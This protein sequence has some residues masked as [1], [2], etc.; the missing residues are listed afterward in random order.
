MNKSGI[1]ETRLE[2]G[3]L[4]E[5]R[6]IELGKSGA[7]DERI[8]NAIAQWADALAPRFD[9]QAI[10][11]AVD[12]FTLYAKY[13]PKLP[14]MMDQCK[15]F[16]NEAQAKVERHKNPDP[17]RTIVESFNMAGLEATCLA[18]IPIDRW[19]GLFDIH[20]AITELQ[21]REIVDMILNGLKLQVIDRATA[22]YQFVQHGKKPSLSPAGAERIARDLAE[23][24]AEGTINGIPTPPEIGKLG[25]TML[26]SGGYK[27]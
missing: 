1:T 11:R 8:E 9:M 7:T 10:R 5:A 4:F 14:E 22:K 17:K 24:Q 23:L 26:I 2:L 3:R 21:L 27:A 13:F 19:N 16:H 6:S 12:H 18:N 20:R 25:Q 15:E